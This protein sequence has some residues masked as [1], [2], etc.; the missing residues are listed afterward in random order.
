MHHSPLPLAVFC[1][2]SLAANQLQRK[3]LSCPMSNPQRL[4]SLGHPQSLPHCTP[5]LGQVKGP[6][7]LL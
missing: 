6:H 1:L 4:P 7:L 2:P 5:L 3:N